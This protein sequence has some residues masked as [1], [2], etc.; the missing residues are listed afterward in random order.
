MYQVLDW[1]VSQLPPFDREIDSQLREGVAPLRVTADVSLKSHEHH[2]REKERG[3]EWQ[4]NISDVVKKALIT[5]LQAG[6][7]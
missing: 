7:S 4:K 1:W 6:A 3:N 5:I 2:S